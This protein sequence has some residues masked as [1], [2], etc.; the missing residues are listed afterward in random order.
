M[1]ELLLDQIPLD[2]LLLPLEHHL[3]L[4]VDWLRCQ[5]L[6]AAEANHAAIGLDLASVVVVILRHAIIVGLGE[7][8]K[9]FRF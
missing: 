2:V 7:E 3:N 1:L 9:A 4:G 6:A 5:V 8:I